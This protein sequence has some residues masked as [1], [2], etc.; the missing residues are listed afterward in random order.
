MEMSEN[1]RLDSSDDVS[2]NLDL[3]FP[4]MD[5]GPP[6]SRQHNTHDS[7]MTTKLARRWPVMQQ[8]Q[9]QLQDPLIIDNVLQPS[10]T[11]NNYFPLYI[12]SFF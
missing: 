3:D 4:S 7:F 5:V 6:S 11:G 1:I 2:N 9:Q 12:S 10:L 8:Q